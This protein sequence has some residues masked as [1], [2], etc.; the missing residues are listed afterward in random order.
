MRRTIA[1]TACLALAGA[2]TAQD[3]ALQAARAEYQALKAEYDAAMDAYYMASRRLTAS[4][5]YKQ[6]RQAGDQEAIKK[7][8][9]AVRAPAKKTWIEKF[10]KAADRYAPTAG[11]VP[12][13]AWLAVWSQDKD[14]TT[15]VLGTIMERHAGSADL[16]EI[17]EYVGVVRR[18]VDDEL[19]A[20]VMD[21]LLSSEH[22]MIKANALYSK[23]YRLL[24]ARGRKPSA[25]D[26]EQGSALLAECAR[27]ADGTTLALR[28]R[29][30]E[31]Q[32]T[33]LQIGMEVPDIVAGD[34]DGVQFKLSDYRGKVV[35][36]D[37]WGDW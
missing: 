18:T 36:L 22:A 9:A 5:D 25:E 17:A 29:A 15:E 6:A 14:V 28:A 31:F 2:V 7:L 33:R 23:G 12:F 24:S 10:Q 4:A 21:M 35:V 27:L 20:K 26:F 13:L 34:L 3:D 32:R 37:F 16:L 30:P 8:R 1:L 11:E 19:H